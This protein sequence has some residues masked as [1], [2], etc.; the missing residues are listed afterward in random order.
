MPTPR[1]RVDVSTVTDT[2]PV[3][4]PSRPKPPTP[5]LYGW[6]AGVTRNQQGAPIPEW[7]RHV[8][9]RAATSLYAG[10]G[11]PVQGPVN[12]LAAARQFATYLAGDSE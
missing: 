1:D 7:R 2:H 5:D 12:V 3:T 4:I 9:L 6:G 8:A 11:Y 10:E